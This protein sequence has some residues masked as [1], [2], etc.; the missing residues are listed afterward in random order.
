MSVELSYVVLLLQEETWKM[1][2]QMESTPA[3]WMWGTC[4]RTLAQAHNMTA[5]SKKG[6]KLNLTASM[7]SLLPQVNQEDSEEDSQDWSPPTPHTLFQPHY[8]NKI[9]WVRKISKSMTC[10]IK[11]RRY[12]FI[13]HRSKQQLFPMHLAHCRFFLVNLD[14]QEEISKVLEKLSNLKSRRWLYFVY[15]RIIR[16]KNI[17]SW[18]TIPYLFHQESVGYSFLNIGPKLDK[19]TKS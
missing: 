17:S 2:R 9:L 6:K 10:M 14:N 8:K 19:M 1:Q 3:I 11:R 7:L 12:R 5:V 18:S 16:D 4:V 13:N 15:G